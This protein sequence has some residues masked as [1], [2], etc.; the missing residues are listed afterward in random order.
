MTAKRRA[1]TL[2]QALVH[3]GKG[4]SVAAHWFDHVS[5]IQCTAR[6]DCLESHADGNVTVHIEGGDWVR[7]AERAVSFHFSTWSK[8]HVS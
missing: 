5:K 8:H 4:K 6:I 3:M 7:S 2:Q 1:L